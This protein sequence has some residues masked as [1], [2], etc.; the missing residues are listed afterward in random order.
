[1]SNRL[2]LNKLEK[3][4]DNA[5][6]DETAESLTAWLQSHRKHQ[7][8]PCNGCGNCCRKIA[9]AVAF[10]KQAGFPDE[11]CRFPYA[12]NEQGI[13]EMLTP[14]NRCKVYERR[15]LLCNV[16]EMY[17]YFDMPYEKYIQLNK[18]ACAEL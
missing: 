13:C 5:L 18:Q 11:V 12:W 2:D 9:S 3:S 15:P 16:E 10:A 14:G 7:K 1:M 6:A 4:L 17:K 8:F